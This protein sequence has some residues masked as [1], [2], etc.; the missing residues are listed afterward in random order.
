MSSQEKL[1]Q[2][3]NFNKH[4]DMSID[5]GMNQIIICYDHCLTSQTPF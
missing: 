5:L 4:L 3:L 1:E 2:I